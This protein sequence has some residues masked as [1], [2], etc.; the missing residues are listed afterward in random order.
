MNRYHPIG[1]ALFTANRSRLSSLLKPHS[2]VVLHSNDVMPTNADGTMGFRQNNDLFYLCGIDQE[3]SILLLFPDAPDERHQEVLFVRETNEYLAVWEGEKLSKEQ[4][5]ALSGIQTL[6]W[7]HQ[8]ER[9]F[10]TL[11]P[12]CERIYLNSNEH[13]R[14]VIEVQTR[15]ARFIE[16]CQ[17]RFP[18][19]T[20]KRLAPLMH[21]LRA[22]KQ[23]IELELMQQA[24]SITEKAFRRILGFLRPGIMEYELEAEITH[25]FIRNRATH[26]YTPIL[27]SGKNACVLH[28]IQ[29]TSP[30]A[31]GE[32]ILMDFG[33]AYANYAADMT[34]TVP[35]NGKF[36]PRQRQVYDAVLR[37]MEEAKK[38]LVTGNTWDQYHKEVGYVMEKEL[39]GL[40]LLDA[41]EVKNQHPDYPLYKKYF[42]HGTSHFLGLD[43]HDVGNKYQPFQPSMVFTCEPAIYIPEEKLGIRLENNILI[44]ETGN[45]DMMEGIPLA[46]EE[47]E[48]L[49]HSRC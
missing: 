44:T 10:E 14:A 11:V 25:E 16:H 39:I 20:Y 8:F 33:A 41:Q 26:A 47:I 40:G 13:T 32:L 42:M 7:T 1:N 12:F 31:D 48:D 15:D 4:A 49:M 27:A 18:L 2:L 36:T 46:A 17:S 6:Y 19:H 23:P 29:N 24:M 35:I 37:V 34:R 30:C 43:V 22:I 5:R 21:Q 38:L 45:E 3:E 28:Y 9:F